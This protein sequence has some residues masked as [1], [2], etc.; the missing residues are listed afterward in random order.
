MNGRFRK[1]RI[2][3]EHSDAC[4]TPAAGGP[5]CKRARAVEMKRYSL[6][7]AELAKKE[8]DLRNRYEHEWSDCR[9]ALSV[10]WAVKPASPSSPRKMPRG[11]H[12]T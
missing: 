11:S 9:A 7:M 2:D 5:P 1:A 10:C 8:V 12:A 4:I 3:A 6:A